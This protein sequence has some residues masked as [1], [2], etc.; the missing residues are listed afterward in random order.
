M[1]STNAA[2]SHSMHFGSMRR[3]VREIDCVFADGTRAVIRRGETPPIGSPTVRRFLS[4]VDDLIAAETTSPSR[5]EG[6]VKDSS[7]YA[8]ADYARSRELVDLL[9]GSEGT[10]AFFVKLEL[11]LAPASQATSSVLGAFAAIED[12]VRAA[13]LTRSAGAVACELLDKTFLDVAASGGERVVPAETESALL[14]EVEGENSVEAQMAAANVAKIFR[15]CGATTVRVALDR[16]TETELWELRHAAS[17]ILAR[18]DPNLRSMQF[19]EDG[20]VPPENLPAYVRGIREILAA[21][22]TRGVIFGHAGDSHV[23]VNPLVDVGEPDWRDRVERILSA[24]VEL[25]QRLGGTLTG[26]HGDGRL[27]TPLL[28]SVWSAESLDRFRRVKQAFDPHGILNPG[29]KVALD[30]ERAIETIKYDPTLPSFSARARAT[31]DQVEHQR[32]Y[33]R[34]R[35]ELVDNYQTALAGE[36]SFRR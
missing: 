34:F 18:L 3:W 14:A 12:A 4:I 11:D 30:G 2:G 5:H 7:G 15:E 24:A 17:P 9:V 10:L 21:N 23:H 26:E 19:I 27:R 29:V 8:L 20:A 6:V 25:T 28:S 33:A 13:S 32:A 31:L 22:A 36:R 1:A 35:L 16:P